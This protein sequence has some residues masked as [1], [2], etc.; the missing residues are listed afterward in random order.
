MAWPLKFRRGAH[1]PCPFDTLRALGLAE[2]LKTNPRLILP[3]LSDVEGSKT[4]FG[5]A[6]RSPKGAF[7]IRLVRSAG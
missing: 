6:S 3:V 7:L 1:A 4:S 5:E 2:G